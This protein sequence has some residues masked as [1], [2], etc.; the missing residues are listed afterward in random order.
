[1]ATI[2]EWFDERTLMELVPIE[3]YVR[4]ASATEAGA[5]RVLQ[6]DETRLLTRPL[7]SMVL[8][9]VKLPAIL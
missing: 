6:H 3:V 7:A 5:V 1:M 9:A 8:T 4:G 2:D